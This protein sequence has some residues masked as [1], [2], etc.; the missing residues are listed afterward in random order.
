M[1]VYNSERYLKESIESILNQTFKNFEFIIIDDGSTDKSIQIIKNYKDSRIVI[2]RHKKNKG[3]V[4][5]LNEGIKK[6]KGKY[7]A[8]MDADDISTKDRL[9]KQINYLE[10][11]KKTDLVGS[12]AK[13]F[14]KKSFTWKTEAK[15]SQIKAR[16]LFESSII[17][18]SIMA[19]KSFFIKNRYSESPFSEDY[20]LWVKSF[21]KASFSNIEDC[22]IHYRIHNKQ[23]SSNFKKIKAANK[24]RSKLLKKIDI[25]FSKN[26][27]KIFEKIIYYPNKI[28]EKDFYVVKKIFEKIILKNNKRKIF[29]TLSLKNILS[30][31]WVII[32]LLSNTSILKKLKAIISY[33]EMIVP[34][35]NYVRKKI[36]SI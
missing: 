9:Y 29:D 10:N 26:D 18:P 15:S 35:L 33:K 4:K 21:S 14:G 31:K 16:L 25:K 8:R 2:I 23:T 11:N 36:L 13:V 24:I 28:I 3:L 12:W 22:L 34:S 17:H 19:K 30:E 7:V 27:E 1:P 20:L 6:A 32:C 5:S